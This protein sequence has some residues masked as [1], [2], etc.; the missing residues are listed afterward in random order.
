MFKYVFF[1]TPVAFA[2]GP[3]L[4]MRKSW[5]TCTIST[6]QVADKKIRILHILIK[7]I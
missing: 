6:T 5:V 1:Y 7:R 4:P 3:S 2:T